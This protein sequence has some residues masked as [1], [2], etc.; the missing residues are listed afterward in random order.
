MS[1]WT[2]T[3]AENFTG[4]INRVR[5]EQAAA[6]GTPAYWVHSQGYS[7]KMLP[8]STVAPARA[9]PAA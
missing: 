6:P 2:A 8:V 1:S 7:L 4:T 9:P 5:L 3:T